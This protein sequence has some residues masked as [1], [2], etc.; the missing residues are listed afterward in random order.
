MA[1]I[2]ILN[3][4]PSFPPSLPP[5]FPPSI[6]SSFL[7]ASLPPCHIL[8]RTQTYDATDYRPSCLQTRA[9]SPALGPLS[10]DCLYLNVFSPAAALT[11]SGSATPLL[12]VVVWLHGGGY[13]H[14]GGNESR[15]N[16]TWNAARSIPG[17]DP[18]GRIMVTLNYRLNVFGFLGGAVLRGRGTGGPGVAA[19]NATGNWGLQDQ[20][21][22]LAWV[23]THAA[24]FGGDPARVML[25][26][27]SAGAGSVSCH[28]ASP[29]SWPLLTRAAA[30]SGAFADWVALAHGTAEANLATVAQRV[31]C[32]SGSALRL[33]GI[34]HK[35]DRVTLSELDE[36]AGRDS[37]Y[38]PDDMVSCLMRTDSAALLAAG[39]DLVWAPT[40]DGAELAQHP[41]VQLAQGQVARVP[42]L[43]GTNR[44][45]GASFIGPMPHA[46][47]ATTEGDF[48]LGL[49]MRYNLSAS[50][51]NLLSD[52]Y[53]ASAYPATACCSPWWWAASH[54][55]GDQKM[56]CASYR[57]A[58]N[59]SALGV[60]DTY[61]YLFAH[62]P[63]AASSDN[64]FAFHSAE[65]PYVFHVDTLL[66]GA[67][68]VAL[69]DTVAAYWLRFAA[70]SNPN[71]G[72]SDASTV[73][74]QYTAQSN[75]TL[76]IASPAVVDTDL[77]RARCSFWE[78]HR[79]F[80]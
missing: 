50:D 47:N 72:A 3:S 67:R 34:R 16:G 54:A 10:E 24:A 26:G 45:E 5:S 57:A 71:S 68:G 48:R 44:D 58:N 69:A 36:S 22:A 52:L 80:Q 17:A 20:R 64:E 2:V 66:D 70:T 18:A 25:V 60:S 28:L 65:I 9:F 42:F 59:Y 40:V 12:P 35:R 15:L 13:T 78:T 4:P 29:A 31:R 74:P 63:F 49:A 7:P 8:F 46:P 51:L 43:L 56:S 23:R 75:P 19:A 38:M 41:A 30:E 11:P 53:N 39:A 14:G 32:D 62:A 77:W 6:L 61:L 55:V 79:Y 76:V 27:E 1:H 21:A 37:S 33:R 73:W